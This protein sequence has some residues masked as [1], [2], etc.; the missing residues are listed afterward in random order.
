MKSLFDHI[1]HIKGK[2]HHVRKQ[3]AFVVAGGGTALIA[4]VW[5]VGGIALGT[6]AI[7]GTSFADATGNASVVVTDDTRANDGFAGAAAALPRTQAPA[8]IEIVDTTPSTSVR[9]QAERTTI[10]F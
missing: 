1:E 6:F 10:P 4:F 8:R 9:S 2:P 3:V 5:L 7:K